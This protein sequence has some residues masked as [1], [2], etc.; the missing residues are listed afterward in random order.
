MDVCCETNVFETRTPTLCLVSFL[1]ARASG[2]KH[3]QPTF[4][5]Y[6]CCFIVVGSVNDPPWGH[7]LC[8]DVFDNDALKLYDLGFYLRTPQVLWLWLA[9]DAQRPQRPVHPPPGSC[10]SAYPTYGGSAW[11]LLAQPPDPGPAGPGGP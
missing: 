2:T 6:Y 10:C 7:P 5:S 9:R 4:S 8:I 1:L 3:S 11:L